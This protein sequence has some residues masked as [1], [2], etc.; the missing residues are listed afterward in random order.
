VAPLCGAVQQVVE[1]EFAEAADRLT[2]LLPRTGVLGGSAAQ[3]EVLEDTLVYA[4][5]RSGQGERAAE[6][7]DQRL[8]RRTSPLDARRR[9]ALTP[10]ASG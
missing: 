6:V 5:A 7:L 10:A 8:S 2:T 1:G 9:A 4:L 3:R